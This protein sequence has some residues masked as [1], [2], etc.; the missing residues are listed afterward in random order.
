MK[1]HRASTTHRNPTSHRDPTS[2][3]KYGVY[4]TMGPNHL[5]VFA[6]DSRLAANRIALAFHKE[7]VHVYVFNN[8][9]Q[10][11]DQEFFTGRYV[12]GE[13]SGA[14]KKRLRC[15][16]KL[17]DA[18]RDARSAVEHG[19]SEWGRNDKDYWVE[20]IEIGKVR[21]A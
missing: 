3:A 17:E 12:V 15:Y 4:T 9:T 13:T 1:H 19:R 2:S 20:D 8:E 6:S 16:D 10:L 7:Y 5:K 21:A 14:N 11:A 18:M